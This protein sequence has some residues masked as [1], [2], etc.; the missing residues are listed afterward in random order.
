MRLPVT[1]RQTAQVGGAIDYRESSASGC[2]VLVGPSTQCAHPQAVTRRVGSRF[3]TVSLVGTDE[4]DPEAGP[5][6]E[7]TVGIPS[8]RGAAPT[9]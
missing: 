5:D 8:N 3:L 6:A 9:T 1:R 7:G 2:G 4:T